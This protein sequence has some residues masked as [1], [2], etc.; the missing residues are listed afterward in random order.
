MPEEPSKFNFPENL[1]SLELWNMI[2]STLSEFD[3]EG[4]SI[5]LNIDTIRPTLYTLGL[6]MYRLKFPYRGDPWNEECAEQRESIFFALSIGIDFLYRL[7][8]EAIAAAKAHEQAHW[9]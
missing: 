1:E 7:Y 5:G 2:E 8:N 6:L 3:R 9:N 4:L